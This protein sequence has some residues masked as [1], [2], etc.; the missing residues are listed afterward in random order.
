MF[1]VLIFVSNPAY[2][3]EV[4]KAMNEAILKMESLGATISD[5]ADIPSMK[6]W[7]DFGKE[8]TLAV[9]QT[10]FKEEIAKYLGRMISTEVE[11]LEDIIK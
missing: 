1:F 2:A 6:Q 5:P 9:Y 8:A 7:I 4:E 3:T 11:T 10:E